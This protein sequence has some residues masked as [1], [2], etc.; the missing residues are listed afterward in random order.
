MKIALIN[1]SDSTGGAAVVTM[2][3]L[4][5]LRAQG[6]DA[7]LLVA[8]RLTKSP[9]VEL[10]GEDLKIRARFIAD[11]L[12]VAFANRFSRD[13]LFKIDGAFA[14]LPVASH[15]FVKEADVVILNW[16][17]QGVLS[18]REVRKLLRSGKRVLWI[19]HDMW[20]FT[21]ICH[22][23]GKCTH[24]LSPRLL[25]ESEGD[26][27]AATEGKGECGNCPLLGTHASAHD[28]SHKIW[29]RK[30][31]TYNS[32]NIT[33]VAVSNWLAANARRSTLLGEQQVEVIPNPFPLPEFSEIRRKPGTGKIRMIFVAARLDDDIKDFPTLKEALGICKKRMPELSDSLEIKLIGGIKN[34]TLLENFPIRME[35]KG[36]V[37]D[38]AAMKKAYEE[39]DIVISTSSYETL[40]GTL[41][42][43]QAFG[44]IPAA[45]SQGGQ[46]D[47]IQPGLTGELAEWDSDFT[48][49]S[50]N[51]A[52][53]I[54]RAIEFIA[55]SDEEDLETQRRRMYE[56]VRERF[57]P[58]V[59]AARYEALFRPN[60]AQ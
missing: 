13:T 29:R 22:H 17:N 36:I 4:E 7:R 15:P 39:S 14:G 20:N 25:K 50:E 27:L 41:I 45:F 10:L 55:N 34:P 54:C 5:A 57:H 3:L 18:L 30:E 56:S 6:H 43:G 38:P 51:M 32:G 1:K 31:K 16:I 8:E 47:I 49:R 46:R 40:P 48:L 21:G 42:E 59:V 52:D 53:A 9:H 35:W 23:A 58:E 19:M 60:S 11:R 26:G 37:K 24:Y 33:F 28:I 12:P 44:C 2:R